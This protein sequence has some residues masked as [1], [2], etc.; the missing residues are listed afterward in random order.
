M[1]KLEIDNAR[2]QNATLAGIAAEFDAPLFISG[3]RA[4]STEV[5]A[6]VRRLARVVNLVSVVV[7]ADPLDVDN[8]AQAAV[9][10][11]EL[12]GSEIVEAS[13]HVTVV[14][15]L[16]HVNIPENCLFHTILFDFGR[17]VEI[18]GIRF[19]GQHDA[20]SFQN[21]IRFTFKCS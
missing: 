3:V 20:M 5:D 1:V 21:S 6:N 15:D 18:R 12:G 17:V 16:T 14:V 4:I 9:G 19:V 7:Y 11:L 2:G 8:V 10:E 13:D